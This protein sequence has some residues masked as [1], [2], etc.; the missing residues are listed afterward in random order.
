MTDTIIICLCALSFLCAVVSIIV[1]ISVNKKQNERIDNVEEMLDRLNEAVISIAKSRSDSDTHLERQLSMMKQE[2]VSAI[3]DFLSVFSDTL[4]RSQNDVFER[5]DKKLSQLT[6]SVNDGQ[7]ALSRSVSSSVSALDER[8]LQLR[9]TVD[10]LSSEMKDS[11]DN[12]MRAVREENEKGLA[13]IRETVDEKL[14]QTLED[15]ISRSF[16]DVSE[17]LEQVYK[18]LGE[19]QTLASGVGDLKKV[20]SNVKTRGILGEV[21][22]GAILEQILAPE[23]YAVN[24]ATVK[25]SRDFV[26]FAVKL[27]GAE[28]GEYVYLPIDSKFPTDAYYNLMTAY[29]NGDQAGIV[30]CGTVFERR[31]KEFAK[32]IKDKYIYPPATTDFAIM[33]LPTE[34]IYSEAVKRGLAEE[35]QKL[36]VTMTGPTTMAALLNSLQMG[37]KTLAI[38]KRS[39]EVWD[40]LGAVKTEF[41]KFEKTLL[42]V[43]TRL[44][45]AN[46]ELDALVTTRTRA[47][48]RKL[49][50]VTA[51]LPE[52][53]EKIITDE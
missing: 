31:I 52:N 33:F 39:S 50:G 46:K 29:E 10:K 26:E 25:D 2:T 22:L 42:A 35:L 15:R 5:N 13:K 40:T 44:E 49:R 37:F 38:Q 23:Q 34:G 41:E 53:A 28:D 14:Q 51:L 45:G 6:E 8:F 19:M 11:L 21:Q 47:I 30:S 20:L 24:V 12:Q 27:P 1:L 4:S 36:K 43:Q 18:G 16:K 9:E 48:Q 17:R 7:S 3:K 32:D